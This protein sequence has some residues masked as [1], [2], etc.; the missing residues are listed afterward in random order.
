MLIE[1]ILKEKL[2]KNAP[3]T[4]KPWYFNDYNGLF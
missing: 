3:K 4:W 2:L 1:R